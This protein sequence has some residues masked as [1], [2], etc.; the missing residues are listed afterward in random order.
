MLVKWFK[1]EREAKSNYSVVLQLK[2]IFI[3]LFHDSKLKNIAYPP[4]I[5]IFPS[6]ECEKILGYLVWLV[7][8]FISSCYYYF[9]RILGKAIEK[10][11][12]A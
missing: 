5:V 2:N 4:R 10:I 12:F 9:V 7:C 1:N 11:N 3:Y 8:D 6:R